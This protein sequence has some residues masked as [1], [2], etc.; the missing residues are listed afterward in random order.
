MTA[1]KQDSSNMDTPQ[2][3]HAAIED[4][5]AADRARGAPKYNPYRDGTQES[6]AFEHGWYRE[7]AAYV[8]QVN[9]LDLE[10][11]AAINAANPDA[12]FKAVS[13]PF[14]TGMLKL[15]FDCRYTAQQ[16]LDIIV[17]HFD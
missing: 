14:P 2:T 8:A 6:A 13:N 12:L 17:S 16:A 15:Y 1:M 3:R 4:N 10:R 5:A 11:C 9:Q 7:L